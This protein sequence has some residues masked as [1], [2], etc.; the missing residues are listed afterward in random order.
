MFGLDNDSFINYITNMLKINLMMP[1]NN[2]ILNSFSSI[3]ILFFI[4][5]L[6][7]FSFKSFQ[8]YR[9]KL[10]SLLFKQNK[11]IIEG[12]YCFKSTEFFTRNETL[13]SI[14]FKA[15]FNYIHNNL[16]TK[17]IFSIKEYN[18]EGT[19]INDDK[20]E[21]NEDF[22]DYGNDIT[23]IVNQKKQFLISEGIYCYVLINKEN[24]EDDKSKNLTKVENI[25]IILYSYSKSL[26]FIKEFID[27]LTKQYILSISKFRSN[28][29]FIYNYDGINEENTGSRKRRIYN[30]EKWSECDFLS[31]RTFDTMFFDEKER[32]I[33][34]IDF[35][36]NNKDWFKEQGCPYTMGIG[37]SGPPGNGKNFN[38]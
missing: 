24:I 9:I 1:N 23:Y 33:E 21:N 34:K 35:F 32:L 11:I 25:Q 4:S 31:S 15:L 3:F 5:L 27:N 20:L 22:N 19:H 7:N 18:S 2:S 36:I 13:F 38:Y 37:L 12:K 17:E 14:R 8:N 29:L 28:K 16:Y 30:E 10:N 26:S 6:S